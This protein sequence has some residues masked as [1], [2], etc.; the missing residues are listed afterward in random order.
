MKFTK[1]PVYQKIIKLNLF[2][3]SE[4]LDF[5]RIYLKN[6]HGNEINAFHIISVVS[7]TNFVTYRT[8]IISPSISNL[9]SISIKKK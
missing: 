1:I 6:K 7:W 8:P 5:S 4:I 3:L 2:K 9:F